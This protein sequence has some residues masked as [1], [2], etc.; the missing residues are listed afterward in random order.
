MTRNELITLIKTETPKIA[1][2]GVEFGG[3][4]DIYYREKIGRAHV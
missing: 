3:F 2:I 1:E 4:T